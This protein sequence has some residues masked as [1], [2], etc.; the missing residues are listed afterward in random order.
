MDSKDTAK[1][2]ASKAGEGKGNGF[3]GF[4]KGYWP[5]GSGKGGGYQGSCFKCRKVAHKAVECMV[6]MVGEMG[7]EGEKE[8]EISEVKNEGNP[9]VVAAVMEKAERRTTF[10]DAMR[11]LALNVPQVGAPLAPPTTS[12]PGAGSGRLPPTLCVR[13]S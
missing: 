5:K 3:K 13:G 9:W 2:D 12:R 6:Y 10:A 11:S 7:L 4:E 1:E 8:K